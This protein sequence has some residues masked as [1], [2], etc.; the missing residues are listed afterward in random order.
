M[1]KFQLTEEVPSQIFDSVR[2]STDTSGIFGETPQKKHS[3]GARS[4]F[5]R[6]LGYG[7]LQFCVYDRKMYNILKSKR[8]VCFLPPS[9]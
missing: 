7:R 6:K 3:S 5:K 1:F 2:D 9:A 4:F 8:R